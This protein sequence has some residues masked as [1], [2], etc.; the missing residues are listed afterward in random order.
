M[1]NL[2]DKF[3]EALE[4]FG[5]EANQLEDMTNREI[6]D[7]FLE[8][9]GLVEMFRNELETIDVEEVLNLDGE[10]EAEESVAPWQDLREE[11]S[12][13]VDE[14]WEELRRLADCKRDRKGV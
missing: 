9:S 6:R 1:D 10:P 5:D 11:F 14:I 13:R 2:F 7:A 12:Q 8:V 4:I 3:I